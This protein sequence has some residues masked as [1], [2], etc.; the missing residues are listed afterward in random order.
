MSDLNISTTHFSLALQASSRAIYFN[1]L[2]ITLLLPPDH[3]LN[4]DVN[5]ELPPLDPV[6]PI[7]PKVYNLADFLMESYYSS[8]TT[9]TGND[10]KL[11]LQGIVSTMTKR[12]YGDACYILLYSDES[13]EH[14]GYDFG[15]YDG[16][17]M[18]AEW[19]NGST[20]N[21]EHVWACSQMKLTA[22]DRPDEKTKNH[23]SDLHNLRVACGPTNG[24]H[25]D[26]FFDDAD[27][28]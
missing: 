6:V 5:G 13:I 24:H 19:T 23:T 11:A 17:L 18:K 1:S 21:R 26:L 27:I 7:L 28:A 15:L 16:D 9:Q 20:W 22:Q 10:L 3:K 12:S 14:S 4:I 25:G 2:E 8:I